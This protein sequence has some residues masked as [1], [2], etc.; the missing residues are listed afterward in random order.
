MFR[1]IRQTL[2]VAEARAMAAAVCVYDIRGM[3]S[4]CHEAPTS[5]EIFDAGAVCL[6]GWQEETSLREEAQLTEK[7]SVGCNG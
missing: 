5:L 6:Q 3:V 2:T 1:V 7:R 4:G